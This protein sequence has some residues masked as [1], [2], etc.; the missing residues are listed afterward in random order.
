MKVAIC[1]DHNGLKMKNQ[2]IE[3]FLE[4]NIK[5]DDYGCYNEERT[6][7]PIFAFKVGEAINKKDCDYGIVICASGVGMS[8]SVNKVSG[9]RC[10]IA[11]TKEEVEL[12]KQHND[13]N[14]LAIAASETKLIDVL[15]MF[16]TLITTPFLYD[17]YQTRVDMIE[18]YEKNKQL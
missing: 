10:M 15:E 18:E 6:D 2:I 3:K 12:A 11:K 9:V 1:C 16:E 7:Y 4:K 14:V 13:I 17:R 5:C 8:I